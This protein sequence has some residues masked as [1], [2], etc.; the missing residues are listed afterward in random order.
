MKKRF[1][2]FF[3]KVKHALDKVVEISSFEYFEDCDRHNETDS[4]YWCGVAF[5]SP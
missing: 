4:E 2:I 1:E 3:K 5:E